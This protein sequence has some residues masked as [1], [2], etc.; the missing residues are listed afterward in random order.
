MAQQPRAVATRHALLVAAGEQFAARGYHATSLNDL[1]S[2]GPG[3][4]GALYFHFPSK[5]AVAAALVEAMT[6]SWDRVVPDA[7]RESPDPLHALVAVTDAVVVRLDDPIVRGAARVLRDRVLDHP[8]LADLSADWECDLARLF[9]LAVDRHLLRPGVDPR[10]AAHELVVSLAGRATLLES[11]SPRQ[12]LWDQMNEFWTGFLPIVATD[13]WLA[14]W[15]AHRFLGRA[16]PPTGLGDGHPP[17]MSGTT[18]AARG[19]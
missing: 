9:T 11:V 16:R 14:A 10:W 5:H 1:L 8:T 3:S 17:G 13:E 2:H 12:E 6:V 15:D 4:K 19:Q 7:E 18:S